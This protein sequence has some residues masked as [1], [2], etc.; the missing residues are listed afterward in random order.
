[1]KKKVRL[2]L[3]FLIFSTLCLISLGGATRA[4]HAGLS[5]PDWPLCFGAVIPDYQV[6]VYYEFIHRVLAGL[7]GLGTV[8]I[9][10]DIFRGKEFTRENMGLMGFVLL[11]LIA[12]IIFGGLTV[13]MLVKSVIVTTHLAL[14][15]IFFAALLWLHFSLK[16][17]RGNHELRMPGRLK[18]L[19]STALVAVSVQIVLGGLVSTHTNS[20]GDMDASLACPDF[21]LCNGELIPT[22][23]GPIGLHVMHRLGAYTLAIIIVSLYLF[24]SKHRQEKWMDKRYYN[25]SGFLLMAI[26]VQIALGVA[27]IW[28]R[29]PPIVTVLHLAT[30]ATILGLVLQLLYVGRLNGKATK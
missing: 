5:C 18:A 21:P 17:A 8:A 26:L 14:G 2:F 3:P 30:A 25:I 20:N 23:D 11:V 6:Q 4:M 7:V 29:I 27:N 15:L 12:Q 10:V 24:V 28:Y 1:M 22:L 9:A 16:S 13:T 19:A